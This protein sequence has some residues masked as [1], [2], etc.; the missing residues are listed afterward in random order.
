MAT[1]VATTTRMAVWRSSC[2]TLRGDRKMPL[3]SQ[4]KISA[5]AASA[6]IIA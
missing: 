2:A 1:P 6:M 5:I 3:V 4:V